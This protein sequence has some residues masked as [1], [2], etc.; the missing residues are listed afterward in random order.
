MKPN[1]FRQYREK[2]RD[3]IRQYNK[4]HYKKNKEHYKDYFKKYHEKNRQWFRNAKP[5]EILEL[6]RLHKIWREKN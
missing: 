4:E 5:E 6:M 3:K 1:Y 2:N